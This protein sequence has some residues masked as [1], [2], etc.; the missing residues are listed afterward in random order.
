M[1]DEQI[2]VRVPKKLKLKLKLIADSKKR[3]LADYVR[4]ELQKS[5]DKITL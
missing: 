5:A 3:K 4:V 1:N 2:V